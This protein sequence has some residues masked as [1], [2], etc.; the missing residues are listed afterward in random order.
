MGLFKKA[1]QPPEERTC[2]EY[3]AVAPPGPRTTALAASCVMQI[4][5]TPL[6]AHERFGELLTLHELESAS[7]LV[8]HIM[9]QDRDLSAWIARKSIVQLKS[10]FGS[11]GMSGDFAGDFDLGFASVGVRAPGDH[12]T[13]IR[14]NPTAPWEDMH[15]NPAAALGSIVIGLL[16]TLAARPGER[17]SS[18]SWDIYEDLYTGAS[19]DDVEGLGYDITAWVSVLIGRLLNTQR[20]ADTPLFGPTYRHAPAMSQPGWYPNP[21]K[22]GDIID[23]DAQFQRY[24]DG[25]WTDRIRI[26]EGHRWTEGATSL[27]APPTE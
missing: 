22:T 13:F 14:Q 10:I 19:G 1:E 5:E 26:K 2:R 3:L 7:Q 24:W 27:H 25:A 12:K 17:R 21:G 9:Y 18:A 4:A 8:R 6:T 16:G 11:P 20:L 15:V 23:G